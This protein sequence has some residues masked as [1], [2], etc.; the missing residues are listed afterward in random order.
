M[1]IVTELLVGFPRRSDKL[2][3]TELCH[4]YSFKNPCLTHYSYTGTLPGRKV[5]GSNSG[6]GKIFFSSPKRPE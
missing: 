5:S 1:Y 6:R 3:L 2:K 4:L